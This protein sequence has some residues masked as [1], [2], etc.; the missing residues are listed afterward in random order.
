FV[1]AGGTGMAGKELDCVDETGGAIGVLGDIREAPEE[2]A[3]KHPAMFPTMLVR[4]VIECFTRAGGLR[5][6]DPFCGSG[7]TL[8]AARELARRGI[9]LEVSPEY[10]EL[11]HR[12]LGALGAGPSADYDL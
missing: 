1:C 3:L 8:V 11:A 5:I 7:S 12:R 2:S 9:G 10:V 6:L 4:R